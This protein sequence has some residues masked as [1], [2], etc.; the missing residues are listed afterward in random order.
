METVHVGTTTSLVR[1]EKKGN[2]PWRVWGYRSNWGFR[3]HSEKFGG[4]IIVEEES[5]KVKYRAI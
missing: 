4:L 1:S 3:Y 2:I 5:G